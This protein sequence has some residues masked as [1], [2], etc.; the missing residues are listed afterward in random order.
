M[1]DLRPSLTS[2]LDF[3]RD[4][5]S[6][7]DVIPLHAP[8]FA[9][10]EKHYLCDCIDT[11][12]V[13]SVGAYVDRFEA[14]MREV[15]GARCAIATVNG[16]AAL[17]V[18]LKLAGV[19]AGDL[20]LTQPL[21]FVATCNAIAYLGATP[22]FIDVSK[23]NLGLSPQALD[24]WLALHA[25]RRANGVYHKQLN[26]RIAAIVPMHTFGLVCDMPPLLAVAERWG[27]PVVEDAAESLGSKLAEEHT[28]TLGLLGAFSFNGNKIITCG[29][30]GCIV[31]NDESLGRRAK[32]LTTTG[33]LPHAWH[34]YHDEVA[35]NYR[36]P[37]INAALGC[38]QL[39]QLPDLLA[40]K[41]AT[42]S[43]Y[44]NFGEANGLSFYKAQPA[45][46]SNYW[47]NAL[48]L[49]S[50]GERDGFLHQANELGIMCRPVWRLMSD[51]PAFSTAP[52]GPLDNARWLAQR[53]VNIPSGVRGVSHA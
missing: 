39:E 17:H 9:G 36:M 50:E 34:F 2:L 15:T 53:L 44:Q 48:L 16:T 4:W 43:A 33:K 14:M 38:A 29:G 30:G 3:I 25:E 49:E 40:D 51:L 24:D 31:T 35:F 26:Q 42:A 32:H 23:Q 41:Q 19:G 10:Q 12:F 13:S 45:T 6:G 27:L 21:T 22:V 47:L 52:S 20:V 18:A 1:S 11:T 28:G 8:H 7:A 5:Y 37:N 46:E